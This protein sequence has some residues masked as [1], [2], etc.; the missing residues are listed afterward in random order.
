MDGVGDDAP[1]P[2]LS[3]VVP[4]LNGGAVVGK[5]LTD[6]ADHLAAGPHPA[7]IIVVD[8]G[9]SDDTAAR[10]QA[11]AAAVSLPLRVLTHERNQGKGAAIVSGMRA[12]RGAFRVFVDADSAYPAAEIA[13]IHAALAH[14]AEVAVA[15]RTH[16][17]SRLII[18]PT[19]LLYFLLRY[20]VGRLFN[21]IVRSSLLPGLYDTQAGLKGFRAEAAERLFRGWLPSGFSFDLALLYRA[22]H[23][24]MRVE[25]VPVEYQYLS[26]PSTVRLVRDTVGMLID[27]VQIRVRLIGDRFE[28]WGGAVRARYEGVT[29]AV[30][31]RLAS[32]AAGVALVALGGLA[33]LV[34][35]MARHSWR[36][37]AIA[38]AAWTTLLVSCVL[39]AWRA[40]VRTPPPRTPHSRSRRE[41][42]AFLALLVLCAALRFAWL[43]DLPP[44]VHGDSAWCGVLG[45]RLLHD[46]GIDLFTFSDWYYTPYLSFIPYA[47]SFALSGVTVAGLRLPS[48]LFGTL[49]LVPLYFLVRTWF[50]VRPALLVGF[51]YAIGHGAIHFSRI[52]LWNVQV[53]FYEVTAFALIVSGVRRGAAF[54]FVLAG[55]ISGFALYS[56]TGGRLVALVI[57]AFL[58]LE[59]RRQPRLLR[60]I[61]YY[62]AAVLFT[63]IP[64]VSNYVRDPGVLAA[65]RSVSVWA[66]SETT[67]PHVSSSLGVSS[68]GAIFVEQVRR[69]FEGFVNRG[70]SSGQYGT[71]QALL[72]P[73]S[74]TLALIGLLGAVRGLRQARYEFL[75]LW[76][77][78]GLLLGSILIIDPPSYTRLIV[79]LPLAYILVA[80]GLE[81]VLR[82]LSTRLRVG[83]LQVAAVSLLIASQAAAFNLT[84]YYRF[85][86]QTA[87][88]P[89]EWDVLKVME[90]LGSTHDFYLYTG[91][92]LLADSS[93]FQLFSSG[94]RI[95]SAFTEADLP[96]RLA[97]D[98]A[99]ILKPEFRHLGISISARFPGVE[100]DV[101]D[102]NGVRQVFVYRCTVANGCRQS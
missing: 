60:G 39:F 16:G 35:I 90:R 46:P 69:T 5:R 24:D 67:R 11:I 30:R 80:V 95:V 51:L 65:D 54:P 82:L 78:L 50:G 17:D 102:Q 59:L 26:E 53:L 13:R 15:C 84:G 33:L 1:P 74:A 72:S 7:E 81:G 47:L 41:L 61:A 96:P 68:A 88:M 21:W 28:H 49:A 70:D 77:I 3:V 75:L 22:R 27:V 86:Q 44:M 56:Y 19:Y 31:A 62:G 4:V 10:L 63:A 99:F 36:T 9:S 37:P 98:T 38:L 76:A 89:S 55:V 23:L 83:R 34:Q 64:L 14:G 12:A 87:S 18:R 101:I 79:V 2:V 43:A 91:P 71:E 48:A 66:L 58:L 25:Q 45:L 100:R 94:T 6:L 85:T 20:L 93:I 92:F 57:V 97:R 40:D 29:G 73:L 32:P 42:G 52:G 8:D